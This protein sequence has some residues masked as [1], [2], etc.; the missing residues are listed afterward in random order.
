[1]SAEIRTSVMLY[2]FDGRRPSAHLIQIPAACQFSQIA[3]DSKGRLGILI[4]TCQIESTPELVSFECA[5]EFFEI[6]LSHVGVEALVFD[7]S[8]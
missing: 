4:I 7:M 8:K 1:M 6:L 3:L 5:D 2:V